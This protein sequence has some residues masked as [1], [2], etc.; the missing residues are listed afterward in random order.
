MAIEDSAKAM[1]LAGSVQFQGRIMYCIWR[2][3]L[4]AWNSN[5]SDKQVKMDAAKA[6]QADP[7]KL[8]VVTMQILTSPGIVG[9][10][11]PANNGTEVTDALLLGQVEQ[12]LVFWAATVL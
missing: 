4:F 3:A 2:H 9:P 7:V 8:K 6:I 5:A 10:L 1:A 11:D 12:S